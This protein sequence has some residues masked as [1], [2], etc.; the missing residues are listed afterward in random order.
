MTIKE[1]AVIKA[2]HSIA[3]NFYIQ[4]ISK[5]I[6]KTI[7][8]VKINVPSTNLIATLIQ[9]SKQAA[10]KFV[11]AAQVGFSSNTNVLKTKKL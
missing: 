9:L 6:S 2:V 1:P 8:L 11:K 7:V 10:L 4:S 3:P 5:T